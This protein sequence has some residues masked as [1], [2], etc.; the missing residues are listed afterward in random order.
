MGSARG[1]N[2][3]LYL[4]SEQIQRR[5]CF[6]RPHVRER[7]AGHRPDYD[8][9]TNDGAI[10]TSGPHIGEH[11]SERGE[12][13]VDVQ[14][15]GDT[16]AVIPYL[17]SFTLPAILVGR[18]SGDNHLSIRMPCHHITA[19]DRFLVAGRR[20]P[21]YQPPLACYGHDDCNYGCRLRPHRVVG[22]ERRSEQ[23]A[24]ELAV[25]QIVSTMLP[26]RHR[27]TSLNT[28]NLLFVTVKR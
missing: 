23:L 8:V 13:A 22:C 7:L 3:D 24:V 21:P 27:L 9:T 11:R 2:R 16:H 25:H 4:V 17:S 1:P 14:E 12:V 26:F 5:S 19:R 18:F 28:H 10:D 20:A 15:R 6:Q